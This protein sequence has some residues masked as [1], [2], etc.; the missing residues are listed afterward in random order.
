M[1]TANKSNFSDT[2]MNEGPEK[3]PL[4]K[5][6]ILMGEIMLPI[7]L[8]FGT[9]GKAM[10]IIIM[11]RL[12]S[13]VSSI[14]VYF[15]ALAVSDL[16]LIHT[17]TFPYWI[18]ITFGVDYFAKSRAVCK[19]GVFLSYVTGVT[20]AWILV[21]M[22]VQRAASVVWPHRVSVLCTR[23]K[24][25]FTVM[26]IVLFTVSIHSHILYGAELIY[27]DNGTLV[28]C[29]VKRDGYGR[30]MENVWSWVDLLSFSALPF[31]CLV[32]SNGLLVKK[33]TFSIH[34]TNLKLSLG[35]SDQAKTRTRKVSSVTVTL[36]A[37]ST[38]FILLNLPFS[39][40]ILLHAFDVLPGSDDLEAKT[41]SNFIYAVVNILWYCNSAV[42]FYLYCLTGSKFRTECL[43]VITCST[44]PPRKDN[45][46]AVLRSTNSTDL[47][48]NGRNVVSDSNNAF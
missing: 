31:L 45:S 24:S 3:M 7:I 21:A 29:C 10:T 16:L 27:D 25:I 40:Y 42:N 8:V 38:T 39:A 36:I 32:A 17:L 1:M 35:Q 37:V 26:G 30:F 23:R 34:E 15:T 9:F 19:L 22:T 11:R 5:A 28:V 18:A 47:S 33:L 48:S 6:S 2:A 13:A 12:R 46:V 41:L 44:F 14:S 4:F 20:S 43:R